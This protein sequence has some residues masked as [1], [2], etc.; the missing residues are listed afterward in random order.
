MQGFA[1]VREKCAAVRLL[2]PEDTWFRF[3]EWHTNPEPLAYH[4]SVVFIAYQ[5]AHLGR[6]T[7]PIHRFLLSASGQLRPEA[8]NQYVRDLQELWMYRSE[9]LD[10]HRQFRMFMGRLVELQVAEWL[11]DEGWAIAGLEAIRKG[12]DIEATTP[13]GDTAA[14][15]VK[16][17]GAEDADFSQIVRAISGESAIESV[18]PQ[19]AANCL[20]FRAFE[21][22]KQLA[23]TLERRICVLV[24]DDLAW[25][26]FDG[27]VEHDWIDWSAPRFLEADELWVRFLAAQLEKYPTLHANLKEEIGSLDAV[28]LLRRGFGYEYH[29][30]REYRPAGA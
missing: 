26:R 29:R 5:R 20:L 28:W 27:V 23:A 1:R 8:R 11:H 22:A 18:S 15:E 12:P 14:F 2:I 24:V 10:R 6:I 9:P 21:A 16:F 25:W 4:G 7:A 3:Q 17:I 30:V 13:E 19:T